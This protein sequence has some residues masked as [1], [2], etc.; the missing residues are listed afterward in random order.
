MRGIG[1]DFGTSNSAVAIYDGVR[2]RLVRLD[3]STDIMPTATY[4]DRDYQTKVGQAAIDQY[5][6]DNTGRR[7]ELVAEIVGKSQLAVGEA[8]DTSRDAP[9]TFEQNVYGQPVDVGLQGRL[10]R[11]VK[12]LLGDA[13][14][15]RL[16][17]FGQLYRLVALITP[18]LL[19][20]RVAAAR[21][22]QQADAAQD[23]I[24]AQS[25]VAAP[26]VGH[27]I[28][29]EGRESG[30]N[31]LALSR[32]GE[33]CGYAGF[34]EPSF[35]PEPVAATLSYLQSGGDGNV[36][37]TIDFGGGTL[38]LCVLRR[39]TSAA[40]GDDTRFEVLSTHG[41]AI[42]GDHIDQQLFAKILFPLLGKGERW[43]RKGFDREEIDTLF[44]FED[45]EPLLLNWTVTYLLNQ[46]R[47]TTP[48]LDC[49]RQQD[50]AGVKF[51]RLRDV[52]RHN[53]GYLLFQAI[54]E[55]KVRLSTESETILD[56][57]ELDVRETITRTQFE[58]LISD[59]LQ[60]V[61]AAVDHTVELSGLG[62]A[63]I[64][65]VIRTGGSS[66]IPAVRDMLEA[67]FP[68]RVVEHDPFTSVAAGLAIANYHGYVFAR[69]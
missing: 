28:N 14:V 39:I 45:F 41:V 21:A 66:L 59:L 2:V 46:N 9:E 5:V 55:T 63:G 36:I 17:V 53:Y 26:H 13:S 11:G 67:R 24:A 6:A 10:F 12:R 50:D 3:L 40:P 8:S 25:S 56:V 20:V 48:V 62:F 27:P 49:A 23:E 30:R 42:G 29:Y 52:I 61:A 18:V 58:T 54:R 15:R 37:L 44:P 47:Y 68:G 19:H 16:T 1:V 38:D 57:P 69:S 33:A 31:Q 22:L 60:R 7:V 64:D 34:A 65:R 4:I 51:R 35:Y 32:L 43:R